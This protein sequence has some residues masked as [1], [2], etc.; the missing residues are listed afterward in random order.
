MFDH[1]FLIA[2]KHSSITTQGPARRYLE[3]GR[4]FSKNTVQDEDIYYTLKHIILL[5]FFTILHQRILLL[6]FTILHQ[7]ILLLFFTN[8]NHVLLGDFGFAKRL[9]SMEQHLT[10]FCGSPPYAAPELFVVSTLY[11]L[12]NFGSNEY[13]GPVAEI[14]CHRTTQL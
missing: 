13:W 10:T 8:S 2:Y 12:I 14:T 1:L 3:N 6:F 4:Y 7:Q 9:D 11:R 5:L